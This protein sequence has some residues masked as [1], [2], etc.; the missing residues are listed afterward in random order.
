A[1]DR[2]EYHKE[3]FAGYSPLRGRH[4]KRGIELGSG[5]FTN[6]RLIAAACTIDEIH[7][8]DPLLNDYVNH[9][10]CSYKH[11]RLSGLLT[12][13]HPMRIARDLRPLRQAKRFISNR[14][15]AIRTG[16]ILGRPV[17]LIA[18]PIES[19]QTDL[20]FDLVVMV[21]VIEHC[22]DGDKVFQK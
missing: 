6:M 19:Y 7:L 21:N 20:K 10:F 3:H 12:Q 22:L 8:L 18:S 1:D 2:N 16:G 13:L 5:P 17:S 9:P 15:N 14:A 4:F 11:G